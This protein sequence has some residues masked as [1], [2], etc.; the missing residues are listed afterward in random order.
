LHREH[1]FLNGIYWQLNDVLDE[2][3]LS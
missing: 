3:Q 1:L 2:L